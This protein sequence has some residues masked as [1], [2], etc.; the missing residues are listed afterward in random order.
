MSFG[1]QLLDDAI[2]KHYKREAFF[3]I[4]VGMKIMISLFLLS[5]I[6]GSAHAKCEGYV[7][8]AAAS[9][10]KKVIKNFEMTHKCDKETAKAN[11]FEFMK[12]A[13][14]LETL[15]IFTLKAIEL[16][17]FYW[18]YVGRIP[19][20]IPDYKLRDSLTQNLGTG[21]SEQEQLRSFL[22]TAYIT[23]GD[24]DFSRW[25]G[26]FLNCTHEG[27]EKWLIEK[28]ESPP[29]Q[30][31][32]DKYNTLLDIMRKKH[33]A[34]LLPHLEKAAIAAAQNGPY[35]DILTRISDAVAPT[36]GA[37][38]SAENREKLESTLLSIAKKVDKTKAT[39]VAYQL[40][41]SGSEEKAAQLMPT[42]YAEYYTNN[43]FLYG[44]AAL[45]MA[46][47]PKG[48]EAVIH[49]SELTDKKIVWSVREEASTSLRASKPKLSKCTSDGE[50]SIV[51]TP[52]PVST[53]KDIKKW[54]GDLQKE[55]KDKGYKVRIQKEKKITIE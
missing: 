23:M 51:L 44:V 37:E 13:N 29:Q 45:E 9:K 10:G 47:C 40:A 16:D 54:A 3:S 27:F 21:C 49:L 6:T 17:P 43:S 33:G 46:N 36:I 5:T 55:Y 20:K 38:M 19:G 28:I 12:S 24:N 41:A 32:S 7:R 31:F 34:E 8:K 26:A 18:E 48:K 35:S 4:H 15:R 53:S 39:D 25:D 22:Q 30:K 1:S 14:D 11:F 52:T 50:W 42:I 2:A